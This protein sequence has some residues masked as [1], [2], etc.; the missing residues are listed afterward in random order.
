MTNIIEVSNLKKSYGT[1]QAVKGIDFYM[2]EGSLFAFLGPNGAGKSTTIDIITTFLAK[3]E[4][5]VIING[6]SLG[7]EDAQIRKCFGAVFQDSLLDKMLSVEENLK[8]RASLYGMTDKQLQESVDHVIEICELKDI[9]KQRYGKLSG[10]QRRRCDIAR[11]L[12]HQPKLLFLDEPTTGL[13]PQTRKMIW[14]MI[15]KLRKEHGM[16][17]FLTTHYMEEAA[18]ADYVVVIDHGEIRAKGTPIEL[19]ERFAHDCLRLYTRDDGLQSCLNEINYKYQMT[20]EGALIYLDTTM[21]AIAILAHCKTK[22]HDFEVVHGT[23]DDAFLSI[24]GK[25]IQE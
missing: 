22:I 8:T 6:H 3:D 2:E 24:I 10:G 14:N 17:V 21:D 5:T 1:I 4:G 19:K 12:V 18:D 11:S 23:M 7:E 9:R 20:R 16:S 25:E 13:D 15:R